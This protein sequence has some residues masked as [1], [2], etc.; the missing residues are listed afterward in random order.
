MKMA[1]TFREHPQRGIFEDILN[2][3][4]WQSKRS[5]ESDHNIIVMKLMG[6]DQISHFRPSFTI[7][8]Y[9]EYLEYLELGVRNSCD[10]F[11]SI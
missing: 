4:K 1:N 2:T 11:M 6:V 8:E 10:V 3:L 5:S 7:L 9:L